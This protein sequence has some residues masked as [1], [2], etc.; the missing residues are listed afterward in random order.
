MPQVLGAP[1]SREHFDLVTGPKALAFP[2]DHASHERYRNEWWYFTGRIDG[3][4]GRRF[5][6]QFTLFRFNLAPLPTLA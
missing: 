6:F 3:P 4:Q 2:A 1:D 5:G